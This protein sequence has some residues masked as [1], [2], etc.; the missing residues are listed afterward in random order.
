L[1]DV[2]PLS[3]WL[4]QAGFDR[5]MV[6]P[7]GT[8]LDGEA[9][10]YST[11][12]TL[13]IDPIYIAVG[14]LPDFLRAGGVGALSASA[15]ADL[16]E[17]R[18]APAV[19]YGLIR[20]LK[21]E[22]LGLAWESFLADEWSQL[23]T[24]ASELAAYIARE[25]WWLDDYALFRALSRAMP[26][27]SWRTWP[28][29]LRD[30][31]ARALDEARRD[32]SREVLR[33]QYLQWI[34]ESQWQAARATA[35][36]RGVSVVGDLPFVAATDSADVWS[37]A[38]EFRLDYSVGVPP[39]AF[40][41]TGQDWGLPGYRWDV[42]AASGYEWIQLRARRLAALFDGLRVDHTIGL[43][44]TYMRPPGG[45]PI[46]V[47]GEE[48]A[49]IA[50]GE[51]VFTLL[52][53]GGLDLI[54]EDLGVVPDFLRAS[55][56]RLGV[57]GCKVLRWE[58]DWHATGEPF[59]DPRMYTSLSAAMTGTHDTETLA[60]WWA[61]AR[62][63]ERE[64][65]LALAPFRERGLTDASA[66]WSDALRDVLLE[67]AFQSGSDQVYLPLQDLFGWSDRI[68]I[69][70]TVGAWNWTWVTPWPL[71]RWPDVAEAR[72]RATALRALAA[73]SRRLR[74]GLD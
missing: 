45:D 30:R 39:D 61:G 47:P 22:A 36:A 74:V 42:I 69:P 63:E 33:Q 15:Q 40:S 16:A 23:T 44:R 24:R 64:A 50:Q 52:R 59:L 72:D 43:Y 7:L 41:A 13:A 10:P 62:R 11:A 19:R 51:A 32:H 35:R 29:P 18:A 68:N 49:Q 21:E 2:V 8:M 56:L 34:A 26:G 5:L 67:L 14:E 38:H 55:L 71:D 57:P 53:D 25:R 46:F 48:P 27:V 17:V 65:V 4:E 37:R 66:G 31:D 54:A 60:V 28:A 9:S 73:S 3:A 12:S 1:L 20:R 58:R 6:L 70:G